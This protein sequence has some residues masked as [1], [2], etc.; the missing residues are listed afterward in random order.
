MITEES[1]IDFKCPYCGET[2]SF[3]G[4][5]AGYPQGCPQCRETVIVPDD[6]SGEGRR[7]P[8]PITTERLVLR[9]FA[10]EDWQDLLA[11]LSDEETF[12]HMEGRPLEEDDVLRWLE[13]EQPVR[14]TTPDQP[15]HLGIQS[16]ENDHLVGFVVLSL[17]EPFQAT[18]QVVLHRSVHRKG[19]A[20]EAL[21]A[22]L[23]FC[24]EGIRLHRVSA[25]C[26]SQHT[27]ACRLCEKAGL[28][29]E[30]EFVKSRL[31]D[32]QWINM[33]SYAALEEEFL[34][35]AS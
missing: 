13:R 35:P 18:L 25:L 29:R 10:P 34:K 1:F 28:R 3:P 6:G 21:R 30:G 27:A 5:S 31:F 32:G 8:L 20:L 33:T 9:R 19:F 26:Q 23:S 24:F 15:F 22:V 12:Q 14:L 7:L 2:I 16:K 4:D 11:F 17:S